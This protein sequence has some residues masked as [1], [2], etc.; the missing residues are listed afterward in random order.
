M[1]SAR[2]LLFRNS[3]LPQILPHSL[4][5]RKFKRQARDDSSEDEKKAVEKLSEWGKKENFT[6]LL[7]VSEA[8][9]T[10]KKRIDGEDLVEEIKFRRKHKWNLPDIKSNKLMPVIKSI[11]VRQAKKEEDDNFKEKCRY[12]R[13]FEGD[14]QKAYVDVMK[15][16]KENKG[17][18]ANIREKCCNLKIKVVKLIEE[19]ERL[20]EFTADFESKGRPR[21]TQE[22]LTTWMHKKNSLRQEIDQ[23]EKQKGEISQKISEK[24]EKREKVLKDLDEAAR[25][26]RKKLQSIRSTQRGHY[27][28]LLKEGKDTRNEG[29]KWILIA[30]WKIGETVTIEDFP[31][32]LDEDSVY[33]IIFVGQKTLEIEEIFEKIIAPSKKSIKGGGQIVDRW[34]NIK[35]RLTQVSKNFN[36]QKSALSRVSVEELDR[37]NTETAYYENYINRVKSSIQ[38]ATDIEMQRLAVECSFHN[39]EKIYQV[40]AK[41]LFNAIFG[42]EFLDKALL[43]VQRCK[44]SFK[45]TLG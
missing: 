28:T 10:L 36:L 33:F 23:K 44:K 3:S 18:R 42:A 20:K 9:T 8:K 14:L 29:I 35:Q 22:D 34:N 45:G 6:E 24:V 32:F 38:E 17:K 39:Y 16:L 5:H 15:E 40:S 2:F 13:I 27:L 31:K 21:M 26:L 41:T 43:A 25:S 11:R 30:L 12:F 19:L 4:S 1:N 37:T 7:T